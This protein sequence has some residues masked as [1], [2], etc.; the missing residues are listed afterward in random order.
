VLRALCVILLVRVVGEALPRRPSETAEADLAQRTQSTQR[1]AGP[2]AASESV[3]PVGTST[4]TGTRRKS[5]DRAGTE[6][7]TYRSAS[8][9][10]E[11]PE[12]GGAP[13]PQERFGGC[14][15]VMRGW[16][17]MLVSESI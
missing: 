4:E 17:S 15:F 3:R 1:K 12:V 14:R 16:S 11:R 2:R 13:R 8:R 7:A 6:P 5:R 10:P 9:G